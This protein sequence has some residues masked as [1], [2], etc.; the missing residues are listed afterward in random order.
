MFCHTGN[1]KT[2][3]YQIVDIKPIKPNEFIL[4]QKV[5]GE[6]Y[7]FTLQKAIDKFVKIQSR[8]EIAGLLPI[9]CAMLLQKLATELDFS[10]TY[11]IHLVGDASVG[12][13]WLLRRW[14]FMLNSNFHMT[15]NGLSISVPAL[16]GSKSKINIMNKEVEINKVGYLGTYKSI[17]IDEAGE[18]EELSQNLKTFLM[19]SNYSNNKANADGIQ[20]K[21][22]AHINLSQNPSHEHLG[23][24]RGGIK[25]AYTNMSPQDTVGYDPWDDNWDLMQPLH[26]YNNIYLKECIQRARDRLR[27]E[28][29][30]WMDG[31]DIALHDRFPFYFYMIDDKNEALRT[32]IKENARQDIIDDN[33]DLVRVLRNDTLDAFFKSLAQYNVE[34]D[35]S[36]FDK[37]DEILLKNE[38]DLNS[39]G[40]KIFYNVI[41]FSM[42]LNQRK[43]VTEEDYFFLEYILSKI[44]RSITLTQLNDYVITPIDKVEIKQPD[45]LNN[46]KFTLPEN[47]NGNI[48]DDFK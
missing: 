39:R 1:F 8:D 41:R 17:H 2:P 48:E 9:K 20:H 31:L 38:L 33:I 4:P 24:Y 30:W 12:K 28:K 6:N 10:L 47:D 46:K 16:R 25:K 18:N 11:G 37:V 32:T 40:R 19:E 21:R 3:Y 23:A 13:S 22:T 14:G 15:T 45:N 43:H 29:V 42:M 44:N 35:V 34:V 7:I 5:P 36:V 27:Q 26:S